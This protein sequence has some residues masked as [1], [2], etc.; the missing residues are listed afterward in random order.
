LGYLFY[1]QNAESPT[2]YSFD[3]D[4]YV[5]PSPDRTVPVSPDEK[6]WIDRYNQDRRKMTDAERKALD[7]FLRDT[8]PQTWDNT[9]P[10]IDPLSNNNWQNANNWTPPRR[11]PLA[12]DMDGDGIETVGISTTAPVLFDHNADGLKTATGWLKGDDAWLVRDLNGNGT[13]DSGLE[14]FGVDTDITVNGVTRKATTG[15]E[16]LSSLDSNGDR[17]FNASDAAFTQVKLWQDLNQDG[18]SQANELST[19]ANKGITA[20]SLTPTTT[21]TTLGT[22]GNIVTG[23]ATVTRVR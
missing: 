19:L 8:F 11:D 15:F 9:R 16:A 22:T 18:I 23:K 21:N 7:D 1:A 3:K 12:I 4:G 20:I 2:L 5:Y 13:I 14:L 17:V 10:H 6:S